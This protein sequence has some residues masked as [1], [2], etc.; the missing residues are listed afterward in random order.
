MVR[1]SYKY[2]FISIKP[3]SFS[4]YE[5][6]NFQHKKGLQA[7]KK[8]KTLLLITLLGLVATG[9]GQSQSN[10]SKPSTIDSSTSDAALTDSTSQDMTNTDY[11]LAGNI[12]LDGKEKLNFKYD[13]VSKGYILTNVSL[14]RGDSFYIG[15]NTNGKKAINYESLSDQNGFEKGNGNYISV[16]N[17][18]IYT[19]SIYDDTLLLTKT[20]SNYSKVSLVYED[21]QESLDFVMQ[22]DFTFR[23]ENATLRYRQKF[24]ID[25][26]GEKLGFDKLAFNEA[27]YKAFRFEDNNSIESIKKGEYTFDID[28]SYQQ[29]LTITS[30]EIVDENTA[31]KNGDEY[32][33]YIKQFK[34][35]FENKGSKFVATKKETTVSTGKTEQTDIYE[36]IDLN[37]HYIKDTKYTYDTDQTKTG[38]VTI[39][40]AKDN[41]SIEERE[42][43]KTTTNYYE[44]YV[45]S[46]NTTN[47]SSVNGGIISDEKVEDTTDPDSTIA[48]VDRTYYTN[49]AADEKVQSYHTQASYVSTIL[50]YMI[51]YSH[52]SG[53]TM[54]SDEETRDNLQISSEYVGDIG[55]DINIY[56]HNIEGV[57]NTYSSS[58]YVSNDLRIHVDENGRLIDGEYTSK[59]YEGKLYNTDKELVDDYENDLVSTTNYSF[60]MEYEDRTEI[61]SFNLDVDKY[62]AKSIET[63]FDTYERSC[64]I[65]SLDVSEFGILG[66]DGSS[67]AIDLG[68]YQVMSYDTQYF[69]K[70][71]SGSLHGAGKVGTTTVTLGTTYN[72]V[73]YDIN[74]NLVY[75][76]ITSSNNLGSFY[77]DGSTSSTVYLGNT[78]DVELTPSK[79]YNPNDITV[80]L[81]DPDSAAIITDMNSEEDQ[82]NTGKI[83]FKLTINKVSSNL[84]LKAYYKKKSTIYITKS[85]TIQ[86]PWTAAR[87]AR[88]YYPSYST[89][90]ELK[91][92]L[93]NSDGTGSINMSGV[94]Y[95]IT[96][97]ISATGEIKIADG[98]FTDLKFYVDSTTTVDKNNENYVS[99]S[100]K[101]D[102]YKYNFNGKSYSSYTTY[103]GSHPI[104]N[105][106]YVI[107]DESGVKYT[108]TKF[109]MDNNYTGYIYFTDGTTTS[110]FKMQGTY[111]SSY[112]NY[113]TNYYS[114][115]DDTSY[116]TYSG[117]YTVSG[118]TYTI[119]F[120]SKVF[121][122]TLPVD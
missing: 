74:I 84:S 78:Y 120:G 31:P 85:L 69:G 99:P 83:T 95:D 96:Y 107:T 47:T 15:S 30:D 8:N 27:Y 79:G 45:P 39:D 92:F 114:N 52:I 48:T 33:K 24:Y 62:V 53:T 63:V 104:F 22:D 43:V 112:G 65:N 100:I 91:S 29:A 72:L 110:K 68:N 115:A 46:G 61:K 2:Q 119:T 17:E 76:E 41:A 3:L 88:Y 77:L 75:A 60:N 4:S 14:K 97:T 116:T 121:T 50:G 58:V 55:D 103:C 101:I 38:A 26:D 89:S 106:N 28:F 82:R 35:Q 105:K 16:L 20:G 5:N 102:G 118:T 70:N 90:S 73:T 64:L 108:I 54:Y 51:D 56:F 44:I 49:E 87:I 71:Y 37:Q 59:K 94:D 11:Y 80:E 23:L 109:E 113:P 21:G 34:N 122:F 13:E 42:A 81:T 25:M 117:S 98:L 1:I 67:G 57:Y 10:D 66:T 9:C 12:N 6:Y 18:G 7:M 19:I 40:K 32:K 93:L 86:E 36:T 111:T